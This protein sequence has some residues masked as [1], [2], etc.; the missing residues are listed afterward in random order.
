[1]IEIRLGDRYA[2]SILELAEERKE[3]DKVRADFQLIAAVCESNPDF[4]NMLKSPI[5]SVTKKEA[6]LDQVFKG[7]L[8]TI[9][10]NLIQI[11]VRKHREKYLRDIAVRFLALYDSRHNIT[12][13]VLSS[14]T[15]LAADHK[16]AIVE[17]IE[18]ELNTKFELT[19]KVD[20]ELIG[21][22]QLLVGDKLFDGSIAARL[23]DLKQEFKNNPYVKKV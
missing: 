11:I 10:E 19:E 17:L 6:I 4:V 22:F 2:K 15:P 21:G 18:K 13:G 7:K 9:T 5:I 14:A 3:V 20:P 16:K 1:M 8:S 12:R 23:R